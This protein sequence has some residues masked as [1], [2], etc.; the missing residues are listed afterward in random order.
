[1][2][3][4]KYCGNPAGFLRYKHVECKKLHQHRELL[5]QRGKQEIFNEITRAIKES[6]NLN[7]LENKILDIEQSSFVPSTDRKSLLI[8]GWEQAAEEFLENGLL[9]ALAEKTLVDFKEHF[10]L[11]QN[12]LDR[13]GAQ[14]KITKSA[15]LRDIL[16]G[17]I[18]QRMQ[19]NINLPIN[20]QKS[21]KI[22]WVFPESKYLEDKNRRQ[23]V[24]SSRGV[25]IR[26]MK[27]VYYRVGAFRGRV[28]EHTE[29]VYIDTGW[30]VVTD[31]NIYFA[32]QRKSI[33]L[34]FSKIVSFE[35]F[36]DGIGIMRDAA[37]AKLQSFVTGD[38]WF[39][40]NLIT[41]LAQL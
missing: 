36:N 6:E 22:V 25:S 26:V 1:M 31:K 34:P 27:G 28:V 15:V 2:G 11:S 19:I 39:T 41:N 20:F 5:I 32:G 9:N 10:S 24:G 38:G 23:Y 16:N 40:Y 29:R 7:N 35:P 37:T 33:R 4:C 14:T 21:E 8:R 30:M 13:N 12:E 3:N 17:V 18:P